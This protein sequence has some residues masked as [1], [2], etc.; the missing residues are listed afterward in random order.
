MMGD[1]MPTVRL[2][3]LPLYDHPTLTSL[4]LFVVGS[5]R[6]NERFDCFP[7]S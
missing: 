3:F 5:S 6:I 4:F 1:I 2:I 7:H